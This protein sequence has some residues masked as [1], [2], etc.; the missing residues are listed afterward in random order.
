M[1]NLFGGFLINSCKI[2]KMIHSGIQ[3]LGK[4]LIILI[5]LEQ[6]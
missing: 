1:N 2:A 3:T 6:K 4:E 5:I